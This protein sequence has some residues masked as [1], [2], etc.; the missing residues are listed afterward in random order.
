MRKL[1]RVN[2]SAGSDNHLARCSD[3][4]DTILSELKLR[5][6]GVPSVLGPLRLP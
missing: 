5:D 4:V 2:Q 1:G 3:L 6:S